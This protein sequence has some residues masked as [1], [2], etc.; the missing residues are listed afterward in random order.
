MS[1]KP[2]KKLKKK[3]KKGIK[4]PVKKLAET[5]T[6]ET[7]EALKHGDGAI[8]KIKKQKKE[9]KRALKGEKHHNHHHKK[10]HHDK[11]RSLPTERPAQPIDIN[12]LK[13][14]KKGMKEPWSALVGG[15]V[16]GEVSRELIDDF[17]RL[18]RRF[19]ELQAPPWNVHM[20]EYMEKFGRFLDVL[21]KNDLVA[22]KALIKTL[23][24]QKSH[25]HDL[26]K[27]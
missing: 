9:I 2:Y 4:K 18:N 11:P 27:K 6:G 20:P 15:I 10:H 23:S 8:A 24:A 22:A 12:S 13:S 1:H 16:K 19:N 26:Y 14:V 3:I 17:E 7:W 25:C 21:R 5:I